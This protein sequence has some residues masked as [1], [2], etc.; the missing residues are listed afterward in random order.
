MRKGLTGTICGLWAAL[1]VSAVA[2]QQAQPAYQQ[3]DFMVFFSHRIY[4]GWSSGGPLL[5]VGDAMTPVPMS[6]DQ[7]A[8]DGPEIDRIRGTYNAGFIDGMV[9]AKKMPQCAPMTDRDVYFNAMFSDAMSGAKS[10]SYQ[11]SPVWLHGVGFSYLSPATMHRFVPD[12]DFT[13]IADRAYRYPL[14]Q[15]K[16]VGEMAGMVSIRSCATDDEL[17]ALGGPKLMHLDHRSWPH[18]G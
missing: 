15:V 13:K 3:E 2:A 9:K 11:K 5:F 16:A 8:E 14:D 12:R 4:Q 6:P 18:I 1:W 17:K 10:T 7:V